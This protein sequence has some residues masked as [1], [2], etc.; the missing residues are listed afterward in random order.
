MCRSCR[1]AQREA[2]PRSEADD[3]QL[4]S[5]VLQATRDQ[6]RS[7]ADGSDLAA[8][9]RR[10][11]TPRSHGPPADSEHDGERGEQI[12]LREIDPSGRQSA[13]NG[14]STPTVS[15][16]PSV[17]ASLLEALTGDRAAT[18][19]PSDTDTAE[20]PSDT[21]TAEPPGDT[22]TA[23][24]TS[25]AVDEPE[26]TGT[27]TAV[28]REPIGSRVRTIFREIGAWT[29]VAQIG[30]LIVS[31]LC[32]FQVVVLLV[33]LWFLVQAEVSETVET[34]DMLLAHRRATT[35]MLP[36]LV[37]G[38]LATAAL[39]IWRI[40]RTTEDAAP[41]A[42]LLGVPASLWAM[43]AAAGVVAAIAATSEASTP[44]QAQRITLLAVAACALLGATAFLAPR[45]LAAATDDDRSR[46]ANDDGTATE[47][48]GG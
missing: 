27:G 14:S 12:V 40:R 16:G 42:G 15:P 18:T 32:V 37:I 36:A 46:P 41:A 25:K 31:L 5:T 43:V 33:V 28:E 8:S 22:E 47:P 30:L 9:G 39:A 3:T 11:I 23:T 17:A 4:L 26:A 24:E 19:P 45:G 10:T 29:A 1:R 21:D 44:A 2:A 13:A 20:P 35:I 34:A 6:R 7:A 38:A 48:D